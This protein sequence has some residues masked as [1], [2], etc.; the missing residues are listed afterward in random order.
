MT[1]ALSDKP[2]PKLQKAALGLFLGFIVLYIG[3]LSSRPMMMPDEHRYGE[4]ARE[5]LTDN[6]W[7]VPRLNGFRYFEKPVMFYW[8]TAGS[9]KLFGQNAFALRL[10]SA[11]SVGITALLIFLLLR[12]LRPDYPAVA[13]LGAGIYLT[14]IEVFIVGTLA[15][16]DSMLTM[17]LTGV[18]VC[19]ILSYFSDRLWNKIL[20]LIVMGIF[21]GGAFLSKG[22]LAFAVPV[23]A[24]IPFL[25]W[26]RKWKQLLLVPWI[27]LIVA[28]LVVL[29]WGIAIHLR[30]GT[31]WHYFFWEEHVRRFIGER[32]EIG[33]ASCRERV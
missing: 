13:L 4:I 32:I 24:I 21:C 5:M 22:F 27:P 16:I 31:F 1:E 33:R 28:T 10:P 9:M 23:V 30:E 19:F 12:K 26:E 14:T 15:I 18:M 7:V 29:P 3:T 25:V 11:L 2:K 20:Y 17:F 6:D 8:A